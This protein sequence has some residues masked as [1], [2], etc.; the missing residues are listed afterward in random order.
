VVEAAECWLDIVPL[1]HLEV[2]SEVLV[3]APP[4]GVDHADSLV[5]LLLM[6]VR[7]SH[8]VLLTICWETS[9]RVRVV[10][11][12]IVITNVPSPLRHHVL[13]LLLRQQVEHERLI[14]VE[15]QKNVEES[16]S[17]LVGQGSNLPEG[18]AERVFEEPGNVLECSP[19]LSSVS[20]LRSLIDKLA[21]IAIGLLS[22]CSRNHLSSLV[23]VWVS[24]H[25]AFDT[26]ESLPEV[27]L[28]IFSIVEVLRHFF[29]IYK[30]Q[31]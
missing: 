2:L 1:S 31:N 24:V 26:G 14:E 16:N 13:F 12:L 5:S 22:K 18:V 27:R 30:L 29:M 7:V 8:I 25:E 20:W 21:D 15:N 10:V 6:E 19:S 17:V 23:H 11:V 3:S 9:V 28:G 4:V